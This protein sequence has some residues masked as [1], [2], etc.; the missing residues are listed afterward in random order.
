MMNWLSANGAT[1]V[2]GLVVAAVIAAVIGKMIRDKKN[3]FTSTPQGTERVVNYMHK[4][5]A[6]A[7]PT[8]PVMLINWLSTNSGLS[9]VCST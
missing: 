8:E 7:K 5:G 2:V 3:M 6:M 9:R 1:L 4:T